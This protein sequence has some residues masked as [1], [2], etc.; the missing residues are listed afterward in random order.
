MATIWGTY[1]PWSVLLP[2][3]LVFA[4]KRRHVPQIRFA[5][6]AVA[7]PWLMFELVQTKLPHYLLPVFPFL[8]FLTADA[9]VR[10]LRGQYGDLLRSA[11]VTAVGAGPSRL[12]GLSLLPLA[13]SIWFGNSIV[14][15]AVALG[16]G[17]AYVAVAFWLFRR[18]RPA[19]GLLAMGAACSW[20]G[21][22]SGP[23]TCPTRR[24][25]RPPAASPT[26]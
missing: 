6:A 24:T 8:A 12:A 3:S 17:I 22:C 11:M 1:L 23:S 26:C 14:P 9:I 19:A 18:R 20:S 15:A 21:C 13:A 2:M 25:C 10:C 5:L 4:F 16:G 7:G